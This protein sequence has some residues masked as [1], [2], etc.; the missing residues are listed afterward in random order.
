[1]LFLGCNLT[2]VVT[3]THSIQVLSTI[4]AIAEQTRAPGAIL[5]AGIDAAVTGCVPAITGH[6]KELLKNKS[7]KTRQAV[8]ALLK[9]LTAAKPGIMA[10][11]IGALAEGLAFSL[12]DKASTSNVKIDTLELIHALI[13]NNPAASFT[14][15]IVVYTTAV[16]GAVGDS[17]YKITSEALLVCTAFISVMRPDP[18]TPLDSDFSAPLQQVFDCVFAKL[19]ARKTPDESKHH[20]FSLEPC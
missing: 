8:V 7:V 11:E 13:Q 1:M 16:I 12:S 3:E 4:S 5:G 2:S 14:S 19:S 10:G 20:F 17:F 9:D 18:E 15:S 6:A